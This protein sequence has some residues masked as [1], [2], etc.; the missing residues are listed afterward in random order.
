MVADHFCHDEIQKLF[1]KGRVKLA[2]LGELLQA[3]ALALPPTVTAQSLPGAAAAWAYPAYYVAILVPRQMDDDELL[4]NKY[5]A[6]AFEA[7]IKAVPY[8]IVP[9]L[10]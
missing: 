3:V 6:A 1:S 9:L 8:R 7:Y 2:F 5:G 4:R 10:W